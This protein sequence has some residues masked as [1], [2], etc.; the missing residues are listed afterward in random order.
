MFFYNKNMRFNLK[1]YITER[2]LTE[3]IQSDIVINKLLNDKGGLF[4]YYKNPNSPS[5]KKVLDI[6]NNIEKILYK[7]CN[8]L[9][10]KCDNKTE[11]GYYIFK[12]DESNMSD[13]EL[14]IYH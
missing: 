13:K 14:K 5:Y 4:K 8:N 11:D 2:Y 9:N 3:K 12:N 7:I 10:M 1:K 6:Y